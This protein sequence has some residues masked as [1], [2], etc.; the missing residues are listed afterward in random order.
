M[1]LIEPSCAVHVDDKGGI[2]SLRRMCPHCHCVETHISGH[3]M[4]QMARV[5]AIF[6]AQCTKCRKRHKAI[7]LNVPLTMSPEEFYRTIYPEGSTE[8]I[9]MQPIPPP[10]PKRKKSDNTQ[11]SILELGGE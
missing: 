7:T 11:I 3:L 2:T 6:E 9:A 1:R 8:V 10:K 4:V 5:G